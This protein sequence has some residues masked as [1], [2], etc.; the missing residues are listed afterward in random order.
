MKNVEKK[1][2]KD[3]VAFLRDP[4]FW[5]VVL[6]GQ[7]L[8]LC[9][10]GTN[11]VTTKLSNDY[12]VSIPTTQTFLVYACLAIVYNSYAIY[13]RGI[14]GWLLQFWRRGIFYFILGFVDVEGNYFV[15]KSFGYTSMLSAMLLDCWSTPVCMILSFFF[16]KVRYRWVQYLGVFIAL[17]GLGMLVASDVI[18]GR[19]YDA[20]DALKGDL[21]CLLGA[22]LYGVSNVSEEYMARKHPLYEVIGMFTFFAT[23]INLVQLFILERS[24]FS[25]LVGQPEAVGM[26]IVYTVCMFVLYSLAPVMFRLGSA[27]LYNLSILTSDFYGLIFGLGLFG[28]SVT[29]MYPF[30][31]VIIIVGI[32]IYH[33]F[34][35]PQPIMGSF[36][37]ETAEAERRQLFGLSPVNDIEQQQEEHDHPDIQETTTLE[38]NH[39]KVEVAGHP[40]GI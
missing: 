25:S 15:V 28:Y 23:F 18:T 37:K 36:D 24:E 38:S 30:A 39:Q 8:S 31:Y 26:I 9:I 20:S 34:P 12:G 10:T 17:C 40:S 6:L 3:R 27:V 2:W 19:N 22:T 35:A 4:T 13:K 21:F 7:V 33:I 32:A 1:T 16:L 11:V 14:R 29:V 5:K